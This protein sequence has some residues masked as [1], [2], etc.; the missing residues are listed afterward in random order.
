[1]GKSIPELVGDLRDELGIEPISR[2]G[3]F[4]KLEIPQSTDR[5]MS[6]VLR[7]QVCGRFFKKDGHCSML[8]YDYWTDSWE[9]D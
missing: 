8:H 2:V 9:H 1:M 3:D 4:P 7:C 6:D 5:A